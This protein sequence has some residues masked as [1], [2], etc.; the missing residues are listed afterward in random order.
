MPTPNPN[1]PHPSPWLRAWIESHTSGMELPWS[2]VEPKW[3]ISRDTL[4]HVWEKHS[5]LVEALRIKS[6]E[7]LLEVITQVLERPDEVHVDRL[8]S[9]VRYYLKKLDELW[10][11]VVLVGDTVKT[12]YLISSKSYRKFREKRWSQRS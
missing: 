7:E 5:D 2:S 3:R 4:R 9:C 10:V 1:N 8:R 12:A 6:L 11:N